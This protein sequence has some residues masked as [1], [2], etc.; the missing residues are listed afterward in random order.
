MSNGELE[1]DYVAATQHLWYGHRKLR[2]RSEL[3]LCWKAIKAIAVGTGHLSDE[4]RV[5]LVG[6][7]MATATPE[8]VIEAVMSWDAHTETPAELLGH[9][10]R[11][12]DERLELGLW[13][14]YEGL[15]VSFADGTLALEERNTVHVVA[16]TMGVPVSTVEALIALCRDEALVRW[17]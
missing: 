3:E 12:P 10:R 11:S 2:K 15:S 17:R 8:A 7:M 16:E 1:P 9:V 5:A 6:K 14:I 4:E 13:I